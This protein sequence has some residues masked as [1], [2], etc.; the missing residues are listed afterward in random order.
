MAGAKVGIRGTR[1]GLVV[2]LFQLLEAAKRRRRNP[3]WLVVENVPYMLH[4]DGGRAMA[5]IVSALTD[6]G[7]SWAYRVVDARAFGLPQR[8]LRVLLVASRSEDPR[9]V[10]FQGNE[11][12][13]VRDS[14]QICDRSI[15][16]GFYWTEGRR[17]LGWTVDGVPTI[18]GGSTI[19]IPSPPAIWIPATGE[20]GT[21]DL[22]DLERL[23]GFPED[24]T[25]PAALV[26]AQGGRIRYRLIGNAVCGAVSEWLGSRLTNM[27]GDCLVG[28]RLRADERW[29]SAA[30]GGPRVPPRRVPISTWPVA[31]E[32][33]PLTSFLKH[34]LKALSIKASRGYLKRA[35]QATSL[36]FP[37]GFLQAIEA[38]VDRLERGSRHSDIFSRSIVA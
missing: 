5:E 34:P 37:D 25:K 17:G 2:K 38:H 27:S 29:P 22:C 28:E 21:P 16:Y 19:G 10:V 3:R 24:W 31:S 32:G 11:T 33:T 18:K 23:Q 4:L 26:S 1:S 12:P 6:L 9:R 35:S 36:R 7:Y 13:S 30:W 20:V 15:A 14:T 8:R